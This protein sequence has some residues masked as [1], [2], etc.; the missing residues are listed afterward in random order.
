MGGTNQELKIQRS[1]KTGKEEQEKWE[2][3]HSNHR[4]C[5]R[6]KT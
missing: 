1:R 6:R 5:A 3:P 4:E 2:K